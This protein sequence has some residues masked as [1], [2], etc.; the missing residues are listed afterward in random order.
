MWFSPCGLCLPLFKVNVLRITLQHGGPITEDDTRRE[1]Q[2]EAAEKRQKLQEQRGKRKD[3]AEAAQATKHFGCM[4]CLM[5]F[6]IR[7]ELDDHTATCYTFVCKI[8]H[9]ITKTSEELDVHLE[10]H[11]FKCQICH[12]I[13]RTQEELDIHMD[14]KHDPTPERKPARHPE[15]EELVRKWR[16][17]MIAQEEKLEKERQRH[18]KDQ[19]ARKDWNEC[20]DDY[21][22]WKSIKD[23]GKKRKR[24]HTKE[25]AEAAE[26]DNRDKDPDYDPDED[27]GDQSS[28]DLTYI[29]SK[30]ELKKADEEGDK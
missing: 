16:E 18:A 29:P 20:W 21:I 7:R 17:R 6:K 14:R 15:D 9:H 30:K 13:V 23:K 4:E 3:A 28:Q 27:A 1:Q 11:T 26:G 24:S 8:C 22:A 10:S 2:R 19:A 25:E 5:N 12:H